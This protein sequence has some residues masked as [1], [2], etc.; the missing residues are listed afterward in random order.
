LFGFG[1]LLELVVKVALPI[2]F[3]VSKA[4]AEATFGLNLP[5]EN[6]ES[7]LHF[8]IVV[9]KIHDLQEVVPKGR[10]SEVA[11]GKEMGKHV[12]VAA[13]ESIALESIGDEFVKHLL[14]LESN[15]LL[16]AQNALTL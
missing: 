16:F 13:I 4:A 5:L 12:I 1:Q 7:A 9:L 8:G 2:A 6:D 14:V 15:F 11:K 10:H 3:D